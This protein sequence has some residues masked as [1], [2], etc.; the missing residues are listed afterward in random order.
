MTEPLAPLGPAS[1]GPIGLRPPLDARRVRGPIQ[2]GTVTAEVI[3]TGFDPIHASTRS[4]WL[5]IWEGPPR[6]P[7]PEP[8]VYS[9][10][11]RGTTLQIAKLLA[12]LRLSDTGLATV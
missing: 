8:I 4:S 3:F 10:V 12:Q 11:G 5:A 6:R 9:R 7:D 1:T 2:G